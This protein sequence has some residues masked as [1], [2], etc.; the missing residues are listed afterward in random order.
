[1]IHQIN[2]Y[3]KQL[4]LFAR[5]AAAVMALGG[6]LVAPAHAEDAKTIAATVCAACHGEDGN[7]LVPMFPKIAGLQESYIVKQLRDFQAGRRKSDIM[8]PVVAALKPEDFLALGTHFAA[9]KMKAGEA[10]DKKLADAGK[11]IFFEGNE[12]T[13]LPACIGCH[14]PKG[15]GHLIYPRIGGQHSTYVT[16]QLKNFASAERSNDVSRFMRVVAKRMTDDE[17]NAVAA[18]LAELGAK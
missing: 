6:A 3:K 7:S 2:R 17:I 16:Q 13:G 8:G 1:M 10:G 12:D 5:G 11:L 4:G 9:Q 18:Y 15:A 14:Q